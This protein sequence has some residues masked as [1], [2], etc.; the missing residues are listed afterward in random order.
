LKSAFKEHIQSARQNLVEKVTAK[1]KDLTAIIGRKEFYNFMDVP[2]PF[3][4]RVF[5]LR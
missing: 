5:I 1:K 4:V 2:L 3:A